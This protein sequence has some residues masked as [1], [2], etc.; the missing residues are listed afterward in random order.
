MPKLPTTGAK[1]ILLEF[2]KALWFL[3]FRRSDSYVVSVQVGLRT[4]RPG[5]RIP[6]GAPFQS[7]KTR[8]SAMLP[9]RGICRMTS[10]SPLDHHA[11]QCALTVPS[12][13]PG[14]LRVC[15][16]LSAMRLRASISGSDRFRCR[17]NL[18]ES[19]LCSLSVQIPSKTPTI[20]Q[21]VRIRL[22]F[23]KS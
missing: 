9:G 8:V 13:V 1:T 12:P 18:Q 15:Q 22:P 2:A 23:K 21:R 4:R 5:V 20:V 7:I 11:H 19:D 14:E 10:G 6:P 16:V 17:E 3:E